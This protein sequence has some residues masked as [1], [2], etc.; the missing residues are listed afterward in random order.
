MEITKNVITENSTLLEYALIKYPDTVRYYNSLSDSLKFQLARKMDLEHKP[1][2]KLV[3][4]ENE[5]SKIKGMLYEPFFGGIEMVA[6][7]PLKDLKDFQYTY[8]EKLI[9]FM[10]HEKM[11][12]ADIKSSINENETSPGQKE[13]YNIIV[14]KAFEIV[15][16]DNG[17][18]I[19]EEDLENDFMFAYMKTIL[20]YNCLKIYHTYLKELYDQ[21]SGTSFGVPKFQWK[22]SQR[23]LAELFIE[24]ERKGYLDIDIQKIKACFTSCDTI[25][26]LLEFKG[27]YD[28]DLGRCQ[29]HKVYRSSDVENEKNKFE[30]IVANPKANKKKKV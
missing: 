26:Q 1:T 4:I 9:D 25:N 6:T 21:F 12:A 24:L 28:T 30:K 15:T 14:D 16:N 29:Y 18:S 3:Q 17:E 19:K 13:N 20:H 23:D 10:K 22:G 7:K 5:L 11:G 8:G 27:E 2:E